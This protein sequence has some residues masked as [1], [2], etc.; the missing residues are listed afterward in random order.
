MNIEIINAIKSL[1]ELMQVKLSNIKVSWN[2][3]RNYESL[4]NV[5]N[6]YSKLE[7][8]LVDKYALKD[9]EGKVRFDENNL[10]KFPPRTEFYEKQKELLECEETINI[11]QIKLS[12][13]ENSGLSPIDL[14]NLKFMIDENN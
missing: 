5:F 6:R 1:K 7:S 8:D 4:E 12:D 2:I 11:I 13:L 9:D 3:M 14:L 10:P